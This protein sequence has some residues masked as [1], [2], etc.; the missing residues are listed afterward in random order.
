MI[1]LAAGIVWL[2]YGT[3]TWGWC[4]VRGYDVPLSGWFSPLHPF[5]WPAD[6]NPGPVR[7]GQIFPG[8][9]PG[10]A[11]TTTSTKTPAA[12]A[13]KGKSSTSTATGSNGPAGG[14][15]KVLSGL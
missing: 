5:T 7:K 1:A 13:G 8:G 9:A 12:P 4:L 14:R 10:T 15:G 11:C 6:G 2:G 3:A